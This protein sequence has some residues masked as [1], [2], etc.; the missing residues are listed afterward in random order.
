[1]ELILESFTYYS[2]DHTHF[3]SS[4]FVLFIIYFLYVCVY[5]YLG[6]MSQITTG[7]AVIIVV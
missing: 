3:L 2:R 1:M 7:V 5:I 4:V 6:S